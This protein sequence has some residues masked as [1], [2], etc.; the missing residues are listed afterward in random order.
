MIPDVC[1]CVFFF[2]F[3]FCGR[4]FPGA[5]E[6]ETSSWPKTSGETTKLLEQSTAER[7][8]GERR[9]GGGRSCTSLGRKGNY[10][11]RRQLRR[12]TRRMSATRRVKRHFCGNANCI[13]NGRGGGVVWPLG[14]IIK[15]VKDAERNPKRFM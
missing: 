9:S 11:K 14:I 8:W 1:V 10:R 2:F 3:F 6:T 7:I 13:V 5:G 15:L 12:N 4:L